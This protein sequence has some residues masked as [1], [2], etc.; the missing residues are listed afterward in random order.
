MLLGTSA[1]VHLSGLETTLL[2]LAMS[3][4]QSYIHLIPSNVKEAAAK[5]LRAAGRAGGAGRVGSAGSG[6]GTGV[7]KS[8]SL[9]IHL[10][11]F[12]SSIGHAT[13][14]VNR[15]HLSLIHI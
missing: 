14:R 6:S 5:S 4:A 13:S 11:K 15:L 9:K 3:C 7:Q 1:V 2:Q 8:V 10:E 12:P